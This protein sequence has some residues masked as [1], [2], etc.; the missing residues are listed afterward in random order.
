MIKEYINKVIHGDCIEAMEELP[1]N[2]IDLIFADPPY[3]LEMPKNNSVETLMSLKKFKRLDEKWDKFE[4]LDAYV[5][6][7]RSWIREC[8][9]LIKDTGSIWI[10]GTFHNIGII[11]YVLQ[12]EDI[13]IINE[14]IWYKKNAFPNLACRRFTASYKNLIWCAD[15]KKKYYYR[16][17]LA[18]KVICDAA[19]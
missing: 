4:T 5:E 6:F 7:T 11:N 14:I 19:V 15:K 8:K 2:S 9:R 18:D 17:G 13:M 10:S 16:V 12:Q 3:K 1:E